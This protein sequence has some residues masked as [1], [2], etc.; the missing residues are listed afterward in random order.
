MIQA[1]PEPEVAKTCMSS[2]PVRRCFIRSHRFRCTS[3]NKTMYSQIET[4][5]ESTFSYSIIINSVHFCEFEVG[6][7][8]LA[9]SEISLTPREM[10]LDTNRGPCG[11][12]PTWDSKRGHEPGLI[13][14]KNYY[15]L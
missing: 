11:G 6:T 14:D 10:N 15:I 12:I 4:I 1:R 9:P 5:R 13:W 8:S 3:Y 2:F 7:G